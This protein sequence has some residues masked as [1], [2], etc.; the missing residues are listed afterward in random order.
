MAAG[1]W[2]SDTGTLNQLLQIWEFDDAAQRLRQRTGLQQDA[3]WQAFE[4]WMLPLLQERE[5]RLL[6]TTALAPAT[7]P[8]TSGDKHAQPT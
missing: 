4:A 1:C 8:H 5:S 2:T 7:T 3:R 6:K